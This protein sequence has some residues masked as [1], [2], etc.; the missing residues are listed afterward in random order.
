[1]DNYFS[2]IVWVSLSKENFQRCP[3]RWHSP[4]RVSEHPYFGWLS[5]SIPSYPE[6]L[7]LKTMVHT[8]AVGVR[9]EVQV[10]PTEHPLSLEQRNGITWERVSEIAS[11]AN[12]HVGS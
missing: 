2:W 10:E 11:I 8:R 5:S 6:T 1:M 4:G 12:H 7:N 3:D 9:L